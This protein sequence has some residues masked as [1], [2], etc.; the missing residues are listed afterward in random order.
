[1]KRTSDKT[2]HSIITFHLLLIALFAF[3]IP[4]QSNVAPLPIIAPQMAPASTPAT[5]TAVVTPAVQNKYPYH[6][7]EFN[8]FVSESYTLNKKGEPEIFYKWIEEA[9]KRNITPAP[10][11]EHFTLEDVLK[12]KQKEF[13]AVSDIKLKTEGETKLAAW[14]HKLI[15]TIIPKF[16]LDRGFEFYNVTAFNERQCFLQSVL[17]AGMLQSAGVDAGTVMIYKNLKGEPSNNGHA[18]VLVK[19]PDGHDVIVDAS[20]PEPFQRQQGIFAFMYAGQYIYADPV[21][22]NSTPTIIGYKTPWGGRQIDIPRIKT[23]GLDFINS[24]FWYYRGERVPGGLL[25][26]VKTPEGLEM[27][28]SNLQTSVNLCPWNPL[29]VYMLGRAYYA[30]GDIKD[31]RPLLERAAVLYN[32]YGL[33]PDGPKEYL[34]LIRK[35]KRKQS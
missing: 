18:A 28:K 5:A 8:A 34:N 27:A 6:G 20:D 31:A 23:L 29:A 14:L 24:Q 12:E 1:M 4:A 3:C 22:E 33:L 10:G 15:K 17:I 11:K 32:K 21:Y 25:S 19:L 9:Y 30:Q 7:K 35:S 13:E 16:S 2:K 26:T